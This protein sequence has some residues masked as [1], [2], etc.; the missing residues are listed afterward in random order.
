MSDYAWLGVLV[1]ASI[2]TLALASW[3]VMAVPYLDNAPYLTDLRKNTRLATMIGMV[4]F[5]FFFGLYY[6]GARYLDEDTS[7]PLIAF[8]ALIVSLPIS[9]LLGT[10][11]WDRHNGR[12]MNNVP[13]VRAIAVATGIGLAELGAFALVIVVLLKIY[14]M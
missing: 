1:S 10:E 9:M 5:L 7:S 6:L 13:G 11:T 4:I 2:T 12:G 14:N 3:I 8:G